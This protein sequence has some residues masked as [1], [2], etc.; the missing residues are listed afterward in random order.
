LSENKEEWQIIQRPK[1]LDKHKNDDLQNTTQKTIGIAT[2]T[3]I[4]HVLR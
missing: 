3:P 1:E 4:K 2:Q